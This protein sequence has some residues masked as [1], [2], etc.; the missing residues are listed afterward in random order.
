MKNL[1][2]PFL[3]LT[4]WF[5]TI[6][7]SAQTVYEIWFTAGTVKHHALIRSGETG[8]TWQMRVKYFDTSRQCARLIEQQLRAEETNLG[9]RL[10]GHTV[11]D[12]LNNRLTRDYAADRFYLYHD[13]QGHTYSRGTDAQGISSGVVLQPLAPAQAAGKLKEFG[14]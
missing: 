13:Q 3:L 11:R 6:P 2:F 7:L 8:D 10:S 4:V 9:T 5:Q 12:V 14:W 1:A